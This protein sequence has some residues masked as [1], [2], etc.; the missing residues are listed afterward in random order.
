M[1]RKPLLRVGLVF[2]VASYKEQ[3]PLDNPI[4]DARLFLETLSVFRK[5]RLAALRQRS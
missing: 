4:N 3:A 2:G 5:P 1:N